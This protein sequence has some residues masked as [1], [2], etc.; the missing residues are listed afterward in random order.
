MAKKIQ[1]KYF[2]LLPSYLVTR[3]VILR[4]EQLSS[5][6]QTVIGLSVGGGA[7][8]ILS[9]SLET[10]SGKLLREEKSEQQDVSHTSYARHFVTCQL[11]SKET[12]TS[13]FSFLFQTRR[14][15]FR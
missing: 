2:L 3:L 6:E 10:G 1:I 11:G 15:A 5:K 4:E 7:G 13:Q 12:V 8:S 14:L 9:V